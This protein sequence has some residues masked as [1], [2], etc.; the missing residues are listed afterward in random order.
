MTVRML[1]DECAEKYKESFALRPM[2]RRK[3]MKSCEMCGKREKVLLY[4]A[5]RKTPQSAEPTAP[6]IGEPRGERRE[7]S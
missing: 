1:C 4:E 6:L 2:I 7:T 3:I 5:E